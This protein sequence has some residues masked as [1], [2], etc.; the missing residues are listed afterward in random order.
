MIFLPVL[1]ARQG[2]EIASMKDQ[3]KRVVLDI[4]QI[5]DVSSSA[6]EGKAT[7]QAIPREISVSLCMHRSVSCFM[8]TLIAN[9]SEDS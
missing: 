6:S 8:L 7:R 4:E 1:V 3:L 9:S 5:K 2:K